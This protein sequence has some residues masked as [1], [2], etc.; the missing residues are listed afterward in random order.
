M[1][2]ITT[3]RRPTRLT[4]VQAGEVNGMVPPQA[5]ELEKSV[6]GSL[7]LD[8]D[9]LFGHIYDMH[10]GLFY[11]EEHQII[12]SAIRMLN[13][14]NHEV[15]ML[16]VV[17]ELR[18]EGKLEQA[19]G[20][21]YISQLTANV[22]SAAHMEYHLQILT[23][24]FM[25]REVIRTSTESIKAAYDETCDAVELLDDAQKKLMEVSE[26]SFHRESKN[27]DALMTEAE[28]KFLTEDKAEDY[29]IQSG[30][31][32]LDRYTSGFQPGTLIILAAR[33]AMGKTACGLTMARNIA[34]DFKKPVA[35][36]SLEM[37]GVEL[38]ARLLASEAE[39]SA[40]KLKKAAGLNKFEKKA[41]GE[42]INELRQAPLYIDDT[43]GLDIFELRAKCRRLKQRYGIRMVFIDY[44]QL[45]T[46]SG[47]ISK[48]RNREQEISNIS[49][50]LKEM[51]KELDI[52]VLAMAQLSRRVEDRPLQVPQLSDLRES[53]SIE[54]DADIVLALR[55]PY[56]CGEEQD[57]H[58]N[59][60]ENLAELR[61]LK[62]RSGDIGK[63]MLEFEGR[64][65]RFSNI[66][67]IPQVMVV[68]SKMNKDITPNANFDGPS[69]RNPEN[70]G[71]ELQTD[72]DGNPVFV[73]GGLPPIED[74]TPPSVI[75][76]VDSSQ[77]NLHNR[78]PQDN[79][80]DFE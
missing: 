19:G 54:Q 70:P 13:N 34:V 63:V 66:P 45:M 14:C 28:Q 48:N 29:S 26:K 65:V 27:M 40:N 9:A 6:L 69:V 22:V 73:N 32:E 57:E 58:G 68:D 77:Q 42:K 16:T 1:E 21:F 76:S 78:M 12:F 24:K 35:Y 15:D 64:F 55:R 50:Q 37:T 52:P 18:R 20:A 30:F 3:Q 2:T 31:I 62:H 38:A 56:K 53:G 41:L 36:F 44:L 46:A 71:K 4:H 8:Q 25:Q 5:V 72:N 10:E 47:D 43:A 49:R 11:K 74:N 39:I 61:I 51:S 80:L 59:S 75:P 23:E 79:D 60:T 33:P 7:M 67:V 17:E